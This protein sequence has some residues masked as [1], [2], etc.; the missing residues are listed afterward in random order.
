MFVER[1]DI[2]IELSCLIPAITITVL[3]SNIIDLIRFDYTLQLPGEI[4]KV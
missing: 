1:R 2:D 4:I 3:S